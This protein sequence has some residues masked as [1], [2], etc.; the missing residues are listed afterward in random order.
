[1]KTV[2]RARNLSR[3]YPTR[4][5][6]VTAVESVSLEIGAAEFVA[7]CGRSGSGK[8]TL[9]A[10]LGA[11]ARPDDGS[12]ELEGTDLLALSRRELGR[13]RSR[14]I[15][16]LLQTN[17][18]LPG[19]TALDNAALPG[20]LAG[21]APREAYQ[22]AEKLL[23]RLG[24]GGRW[25]AFPQELSGGQQRRVA[26][27]RALQ[28]SPALLLLDE[29]TSNLDPLAEEEILQLLRELRDERKMA[30]L[31]VTHGDNL[32]ALADRVL[33]MTSGRLTEGKVPKALPARPRLDQDSLPSFEQTPA[34]LAPSTPQ[35][36]PESDWRGPFSFFLA[37]LVIGI[38]LVFT[39]DRLVA[40]G[41]GRQLWAK[42]EKKRIA[43]E[44]A[45]RHLR[46][47]IESVQASGKGDVE[48]S[49]YLQNYDPTRTFYVLGPSLRAFYQAD[50]RWESIPVE[51]APGSDEAI[52]EILPA[53]TLVPFSFSLLP[54]KYDEL[55]LGY[56]H[57]RFSGAMVVSETRDAKGDLFERQDDYYI[58]LK[59]PRL[60]D[61][62]IR[63]KNGWKPGSVVPPWMAMPAH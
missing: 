15:G 18:L 61:D 23:T 44:I 4:R 43:E 62:Q 28:H 27:A 1:M 2:L 49:L 9:M 20:I 5:G 25:D 47:D 63:R 3:I 13:I 55:I 60:T 16:F 35:A 56:F 32:A 11:L 45:F 7:V 42:Q 10:L 24:M 58:Y 30:I 8:S 38:A 50:G 53:K 54:A 26:L 57:I 14:R 39:A 31:A 17:S 41:Q 29:P 46:A 21:D 6:S 22:R 48:A 33:Q 12:L 59:D 52:R 19:L 36:A 51:T 40:W 34:G 37:T